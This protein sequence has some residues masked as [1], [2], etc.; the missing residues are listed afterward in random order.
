[1][2]FRIRK[3][4]I[5]PSIF[6]GPSHIPT[7]EHQTSWPATGT[8][9]MQCYTYSH[10][11]PPQMMQSLLPCIRTYRGCLLMIILWCPQVMRFPDILNRCC[12]HLHLGDPL[13]Y[14]WNTGSVNFSVYNN[15][16]RWTAVLFYQGMANCPSG[17]G[18]H[19][20]KSTSWVLHLH[21]KTSTKHKEVFK[22]MA[23][24]GD[25]SVIG[26]TF[27]SVHCIS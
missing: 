16:M 26:Q 1:M 8:G 14:L 20:R 27:I 7:V 9:G 21:M 2:E 12:D 22:S 19:S 25:R 3:I 6:V 23:S 18:M 10:G 24:S 17:R 13:H 5:N 15:C 11:P 4:G